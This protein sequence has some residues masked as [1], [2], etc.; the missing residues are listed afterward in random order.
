LASFNSSDF[1]SP[2]LTCP[3]PT[4]LRNNDKGKN[5]STVNWSFSFTDNSLIY[6]EPGIT[7]DSFTV[8]LKI[9]DKNVD[10]SLPKLLGIGTNTVKYTVTDAAGNTKS[11]TFTVEV[12]GEFAS[13]EIKLHAGE[14]ETMSVTVTGERGVSCRSN[15]LV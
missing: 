4:I 9:N 2:T 8:V 1:K 14:S 11:C 12:K 7:N 13:R 15:H 3:G 5:V 6:N 10:T